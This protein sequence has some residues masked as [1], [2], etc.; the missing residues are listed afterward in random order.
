MFYILIY[1]ALVSGVN[2][3]NQISNEHFLSRT[4]AKLIGL[5]NTTMVHMNSKEILLKCVSI[6]ENVNKST[7]YMITKTK[8][9]KGQLFQQF[10]TF[11]YAYKDY[12]SL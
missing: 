2:A 5:F 6:R 4:C 1:F 10:Y 7:A 12:I 8:R 11:D 9:K 3:I